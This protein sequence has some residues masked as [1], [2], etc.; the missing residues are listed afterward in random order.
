MKLLDKK[1]Y[2]KLISPLN[3]VKINN[4]FA[5]SVVEHHVTG[6][7]F[8]DNVDHPGTFY[9]VHPYGMS[10]L[11][12]DPN[13]EAFNFEFKNYA[14]NRHKTRNSHE[15]MQA[16]PDSWDDKLLDLFGRYLVKHKD[17]SANIKSGII[18][19]NTRINFKFCTDSYFA[20]RQITLP[21]DSRIV[22]TD[23]KIFSEMKGKVIPHNFWDGADDFL[24]Q[25]I[26][27][28]LFYKNQLATTAYASFIHDDKLELGIET[29]PEFRGKGFAHI[30]CATLI[31]Y[32]INNNYEPIW[33]CSLENTN[34]YKLAQKLGFKPRAKISYYRL[35]N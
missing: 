14:L 29:L 19:L 26:G 9:V 23:R 24:D 28:S 18:E 16:Y 34:S 10:L 22:R 33:A 2:N 13:N 11:F 35:S 8:V 20:N 3:N 6:K 17:N 1:L 5:R 21:K 30:T 15:W 27:Y 4:L 31:D 12:G 32:C 25:G 7:V